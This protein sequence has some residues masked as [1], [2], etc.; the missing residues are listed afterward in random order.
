MNR[1][2]SS[3]EGT[4]HALP[5]RSVLLGLTAAL[6]TLAAMFWLT[7]TEPP[8]ANAD[9][10]KAKAAQRDPRWEMPPPLHLPIRPPGGGAG[11]GFVPD[12]FA[13][14]G[15][16]RDLLSRFYLN[17]LV[18]ERVPLQK[19]AGLLMERLRTDDAQ[20]RELLPRLR[21]VVPT[22]AASRLVSFRA[23]AMPFLSALESV[24]ALTG[25]ELR[26]TSE[27]TLELAPDGQRWPQT[28][29]RADLLDFLDGLVNE[30]GTAAWQD[31]TR[32]AELVVDARSL[33]IELDLEQPEWHMAP[34]TPGQRQALKTMTDAREALRQLPLPEYELRLAE[35]V[36]A[37]PVGSS[38]PPGTGPA[39]APAPSA[40][41]ASAT[42]GAAS[43]GPEAPARP[44]VP[45]MRAADARQA[46]AAAG[47]RGPLRVSVPY[48]IAGQGLGVLEY[49]IYIRPTAFGGE[50]VAM[51]YSQ[52]HD[53][54]AVVGQSRLQ[55]LDLAALNQEVVRMATGD[56]QAQ[57]GVSMTGVSGGAH[58]TYGLRVVVGFVDTIYGFTKTGP[59]SLQLSENSS[60][61]AELL[62]EMAAMAN[63]TAG[64]V[65]TPV[66]DAAPVTPV[67]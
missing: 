54:V 13:V 57:T 11:T 21:I 8:P 49:L 53:A 66:V 6:L 35:T 63:A 39:A 16:V 55:G 43:G 3:P 51:L 45:V 47:L 34:L 27:T 50:M 46:I 56:D 33:G 10:E 15:P 9:A 18:L 67:E 26:Q 4:S 65:L 59:G 28:A 17:D 7:R 62:A 36:P 32:L 2:G 20:A 61:P 5:I 44:Q 12:A 42:E 24:A 58:G 48:E 64:A 14:K 52:S 30:D 31:E 25:C 41:P 60:L 1:S 22:A 37:A 38:V 40:Q 29:A 23:G 19:A